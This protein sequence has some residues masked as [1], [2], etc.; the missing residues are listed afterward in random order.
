[1]TPFYLPKVA[2]HLELHETDYVNSAL[3]HAR[4][5]RWSTWT[6]YLCALD[7]ALARYF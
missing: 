7:M 3:L 5:R 2:K 6:M 4:R 1:M